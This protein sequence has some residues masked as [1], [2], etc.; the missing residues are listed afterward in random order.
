MAPAGFE[1]VRGAY[2]ALNQGDPDPLAALFT[3]DTVWHDGRI[4]H[5]QDYRR[6]RQALT[7]ARAA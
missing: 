7:A 6:R 1:P 5:I 4:A 2:E 3:P